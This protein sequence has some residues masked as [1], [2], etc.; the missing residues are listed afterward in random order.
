MKSSIVFHQALILFALGMGCMWGGCQ[1]IADDDPVNTQTTDQTSQVDITTRASGD[2]E[3]A[4]PV[5]VYVFNASNGKLVASQTIHSS[6]ESIS[7]A[8]DLG[9]YK[10]VAIAGTSTGYTVPSNPTLTDVVSIA[11]AG[12]SSQPMMM[13]KADFS[14]TKTGKTVQLEITMSY[15]VSKLSVR[16]TDIPTDVTGVRLSLSSFYTTLTF[17]GTY[18]GGGKTVEL[19]CTQDGSGVWTATGLYLFPT[20]KSETLYSIAFDYATRTETYAYTYPAALKAGSPFSFVGSY[21]GCAYI[22]GTL[23][24]S[25]WGETVEVNFSF[26]SSSSQTSS[27]TSSSTGNSTA[28]GTTTVTSG[29]IPQVGDIWN[30]GIVVKVTKSSDTEAD[31]L[32]MSLAEW[33]CTTSEAESYLTSYQSSTGLAWRMLTDT[34]AKAVKAAFDATTLAAVNAQITSLPGTYDE[35]SNEDGV[36]YLCLKGEVMYTFRFETTGSVTK[37]GTSKNYLLRPVR[38]VHYKP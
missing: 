31:V 38:E 35:I 33:S 5:S 32:L 18:G 21:Q 36:R 12:Y 8:L 14:V 13:G 1:Q 34:E 2:A 30:D 27:T 26:G 10:I 11:S 17:N 28:S 24:V 29:D 20:D 3:I 7:Q 37:A 22:D 23:A 19:S 16:L 9:E 4:Y 25:G 15:V 6:T